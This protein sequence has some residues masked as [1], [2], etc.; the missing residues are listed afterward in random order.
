MSKRRNDYW[1]VYRDCSTKTV[2]LYPVTRYYRK[3]SSGVCKSFTVQFR[4]FYV[5]VPVD[6]PFD[7]SELRRFTFYSSSYCSSL[8]SDGYILNTHVSDFWNFDILMDSCI[9][10]IDNSAHN[11]PI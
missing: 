10:I 1:L 4:R 3:V 11:L 6:F 2:T 5:C 9:T 7:L 8:F